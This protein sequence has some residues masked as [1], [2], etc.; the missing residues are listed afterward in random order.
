MKMLQYEIKKVF[1]KFKNRMA[2][3]LLLIILIATSILTMN[4]VE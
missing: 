2:M 4:R 3:I 1:S